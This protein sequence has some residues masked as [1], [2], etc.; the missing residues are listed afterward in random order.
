MGLFRKKKQ[1]P[2]F[3]GSVPPSCAYCQ[4]N[5]GRGGEVV[6]ALRQKPAED[7]CKKYRYDPLRR[8]PKPA[9]SLRA[10]QYKPEDFQ[11]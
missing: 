7:A 9:P 1:R 4:H 6:C 11:L 8:E 10:G 3:G 2:F 5:S